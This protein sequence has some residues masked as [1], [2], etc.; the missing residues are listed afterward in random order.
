V[1]TKAVV[2]QARD[3]DYVIFRKLI[4]VF[5]MDCCSLIIGLGDVESY[6]DLRRNNLGAKPAFALLEMDIEIPQAAYE[7]S[8]VVKLRQCAVDMICLANVGP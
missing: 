4:F 2:E 3:R 8:A 5:K 7:H 1:Y 6:M